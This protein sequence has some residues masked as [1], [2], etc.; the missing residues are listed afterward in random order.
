[1]INSRAIWD[2]A[3][4]LY[5]SSATDGG[6]SSCKKDSREEFPWNGKKGNPT[7]I[8]TDKLVSFFLIKGENYALSPV[9]W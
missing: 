2:E 5:P 4:L 6:Y 8:G 7:M 3:S 1:M 9:F